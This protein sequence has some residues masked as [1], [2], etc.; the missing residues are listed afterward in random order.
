MAKMADVYGRRCPDTQKR[1][2]RDV[3]VRQV[4]QPDPAA[5]A[6]VKSKQASTSEEMREGERTKCVMARVD[7]TV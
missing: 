7:P 1:D 6:P 4:L 5:P 3:K 2:G